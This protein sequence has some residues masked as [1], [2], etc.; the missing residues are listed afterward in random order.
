LFAPVELLIAD[1]P[2][3]RSSLI[4]VK[5]S[6]LMVVEPNPELLSAATELDTKLAALAAKV[7]ATPA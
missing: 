3:G 4:Y 1:E 7:T 5:P 2:D 6:S